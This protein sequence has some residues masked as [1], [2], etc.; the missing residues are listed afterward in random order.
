MKV[1]V[2]HAG[3]G[4]ETGCCGHIVE[5]EDGRRH[6]EFSHPYGENPQAFARELAEGIIRKEWPECIDSIDWE[7]M[8]VEVI[9]D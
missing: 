7:T 4:C 1:R 5:I 9:D 8:T 2:F 3:Y 6:F